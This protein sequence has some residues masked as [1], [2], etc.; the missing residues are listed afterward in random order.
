MKHQ[1]L[2]ISFSVLL[3]CASLVFSLQLFTHKY[4]TDE[5]FLLVVQV[6][7]F[8]FL[9]SANYTDR[10]KVLIGRRK[11]HL[12]IIILLSIVLSINGLL[13]MNKTKNSSASLL[14]PLHG[15]VATYN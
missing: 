3:M 12:A 14:L 13:L 2:R 10:K 6:L 5:Q 7:L 11:T 4:G 8:I 9:S 1:T 15:S